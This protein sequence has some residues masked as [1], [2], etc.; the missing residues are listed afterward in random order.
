MPALSDVQ[1]AEMVEIT[2]K[3]V[4]TLILG[5]NLCPFAKAPLL[6]EAV[7]FVVHDTDSMRGFVEAFC[8][9]IDWL[10][11]HPET[12]TTLMILPRLGERAHFLPF[13][14]YCE[15]TIVLN[16]WTAD[17]Q[18]V[19]FHPLA[20]FEGLAPDSPQNL[21]GMAPLPVLHLLRVASVEALGQAVKKD[22]QA[23][24]DRILKKMSPSEVKRLWEKILT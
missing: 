7:R 10:E 14:Q 5:L 17:Y 3:W 23:E 6:R 21:T 13:V 12:E 15:E 24:N 16:Q 2:R 19:G 20:R 1:K 8:D 9:E 18:I 11:Q 4:E 22:V